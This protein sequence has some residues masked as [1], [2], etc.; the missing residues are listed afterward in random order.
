MK[1]VIICSG[2]AP[3]MSLLEKEIDEDTII[4]CADG[5]ANHLYNSSI[6]PHY[7]L[8]DFDSIAPEVLEYFRHQKVKLESY[9]VE[10]DDTD[11]ELALNK[12][13]ELGAKE[14]VF[15]G[16]IG[17]RIDHVYGN[18]GLLKRCINAGVKGS[19]KDEHNYIFLMDKSATLYGSSGD[20]FSLQSFSGEVKNLN[21]RGAKYPLY[22]YDLEVGDPI[23]ISNMFLN[24]KVE[25]TF[26]RGTLLVFYT[27]D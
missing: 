10:K 26:D 2:N 4:I 16:C 17:S 9:P 23:T 7:L 6:I 5:G 24:E 19:I 20:T 8:G 25:I 18:I 15:L 21:I 13:I 27:M 1:A 11:S 3:S 22:N 14:V 12:A